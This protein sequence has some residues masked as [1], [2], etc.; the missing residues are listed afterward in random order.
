MSS[1]SHDIKTE[2]IIHVLLKQEIQGIIDNGF[3]QF[4][5]HALATESLE[6]LQSFLE[7]KLVSKEAIQGWAEKKLKLLP[8]NG[9]EHFASAFGNATME[10]L[11][12]HGVFVPEWTKSLAYSWENAK[13]G[14]HEL[15][16]VQML[17][18]AIEQGGDISGYEDKIVEYSPIEV[19]ST[20]CQ[21]GFTQLSIY[22]ARKLETVQFIHEH[23]GGIEAQLEHGT[24]QL[25]DLLTKDAA[26]T[27]YL[28]NLD[29]DFRL[30][31]DNA[32]V[33]SAIENGDFFEDKWSY[34]VPLDL[35][36]LKLFLQKGAD[37]NHQD[38]NG[39]T[40]LYRL[41]YRPRRDLTFTIHEKTRE[42]MCALLELG[43]DPTIL[44]HEGQCF[45]DRISQDTDSIHA[46]LK[47]FPITDVQAYNNVA[48]AMFQ[49]K[50][51]YVEVETQGWIDPT[52][53]IPASPIEIEPFIHEIVFPKMLLTSTRR[54]VLFDTQSK[55]LLS[56]RLLV[57]YLYPL[58]QEQDVIRH[59]NHFARELIIAQPKEQECIA[60][61][62]Y[63]AYRHPV[64]ATHLA[65]LG[66]SKTSLQTRVTE[67]FT[68]RASGLKKA[69]Q[70][71]VAPLN[72]LENWHLEVMDHA[73]FVHA[74]EPFA[75][76][77][78]QNAYD[79]G[80]FLTEDRLEKGHKEHFYFLNNVTYA[81]Q[82]DESVRLYN[83]SRQGHLYPRGY[84]ENIIKQ[85]PYQ[86]IHEYCGDG[87][88]DHTT[89]LCENPNI[90][91]VYW[92]YIDH[93]K[94]NYYA[95]KDV[96]HRRSADWD[97]VYKSE[98]EYR[99]ALKDYQTQMAQ[100]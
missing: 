35:E 45:L 17:I 36:T 30:E 51:L 91:D 53:L 33:I 78:Y 84:F 39:N 23:A 66:I 67:Y 76:T 89:I 20:A 61:F 71:I 24:Q 19:L 28:L 1:N 54:I 21:H 74:I 47:R 60:L 95:M 57:E 41:A 50:T 29:I 92:A 5:N 77:P 16:Y 98:Q 40:L 75:Y 64:Y 34:R 88:G 68:R 85:Q 99:Q 79:D 37:I 100:S 93:E 46:L 18:L 14:P 31:S 25:I 80:Y 63:S 87:Y 26:I 44:N 56:E 22:A 96:S 38:Q 3:Y 15:T 52:L 94:A 42:K 13:Y 11:I 12:K 7:A 62:F 43:A 9:N 59:I 32:D 4:T 8:Y 83:E 73:H 69:Y 65:L 10:I 90:V 2:K 6:Y 72:D 86:G 70:F 55:I 48:D 49:A 27:Q 82:L 97:W 81:A 58:M